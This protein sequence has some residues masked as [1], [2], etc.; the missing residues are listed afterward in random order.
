L[1]L[2]VGFFGHKC[3]RN[4]SFHAAILQVYLLAEGVAIETI[5]FA[6]GV[7]SIAKML[8]EIPTGIFADRFGRRRSLFAGIFFRSLGLLWLFADPGAASVIGSFVLM[9]LGSAFLSGS[10]S[11]LVYDALRDGNEAVSY[12]GFESRGYMV[13]L[14]VYGA[15]AAIGSLVAAHV[16]LAM[17]VL[18]SAIGSII[19]I[20]FVMLLPRD[21]GEPRAATRAQSPLLQFLRV[22]REILR[23]PSLRA[24][25]VAFVAFN[26]LVDAGMLLY[27]PLL[28]E[29]GVATIWFGIGMGLI[30]VVDM[31]AVWIGNRPP[32]SGLSRGASALL[33]N[34]VFAGFVLCCLV[35]GWL[36]APFA[37][38][39]VA[40]GYSLHGAADGLQYPLVRV[41]ANE[42]FAGSE[43][44]TMLSVLSAA[45]L[46]VMG[47]M[48]SINGV[49][50]GIGGTQLAFVA[51]LAI[52]AAG[53]I[54]CWSASRRIPAP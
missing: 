35:A 8:F 21:R 27:Q 47:A 40:I 1:R 23:H 50:I 42:A 53:A 13:E 10:D 5:F 11:A 24:A 6:Y 4:L 22:M 12:R 28:I 7:W 15:A 14:A 36:P 54:G 16:D 34:L 43:R 19:G 20:V 18:L 2:A 41:W 39:L 46:I 49:L 51:V 31:A 38:L 3:C 26:V 45:S 9:S 52:W 44:A 37:L 32:L 25:A 33:V 17:P 29:Q 30:V 48:H